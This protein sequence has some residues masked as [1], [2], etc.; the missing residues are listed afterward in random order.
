MITGAAAAFV[1]ALAGAA[2]VA[3]GIR[4]RMRMSAYPQ[5]LRAASGKCGVW[6]KSQTAASLKEWNKGQS[7][8]T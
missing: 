7:R 2:V 5:H 4:M 1:V 6:Q 8:V 3:V